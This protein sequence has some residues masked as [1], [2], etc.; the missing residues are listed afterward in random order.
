MSFLTSLI[1][2]YV[3]EELMF[4]KYSCCLAVQLLC[5]LTMVNIEYCLR[6]YKIANEAEK[7][8]MKLPY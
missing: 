6:Y 4:L 1:I 7:H 2:S 5:T 3:T 8:S